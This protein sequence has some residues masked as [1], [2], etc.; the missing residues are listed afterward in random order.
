[1]DFAYLKLKITLADGSLSGFDTA[2]PYTIWNE[3]TAQYISAHGKNKQFYLNELSR[4]QNPDGSMN[5]SPE[6]FEKPG[7]WHVNW[8]S[9]AAT[10]W[11]Y[12]AQTVSPFHKGVCRGAK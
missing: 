9:V 8:P 10:S 2:G 1:L 12:F 11:Y 5:H 7:V 4:Q 6:N 3:G